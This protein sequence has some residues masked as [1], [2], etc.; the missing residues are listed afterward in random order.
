MHDIL[1][2]ATLALCALVGL[3]VGSFLNVVIY[4]LP[5]KCESIVK[6]RSFCPSCRK[7]IAWFD[8]VPLL[9][10]LILRGKCRHCGAK[11]SAR[12]FLVELFSGA[13]VTWLAY[14]FLLSRSSWEV[15]APT[16]PLFAIYS[17]LALAMVACSVIDLRLRIIPDEI[18]KPFMLL[19]PIVSF[20]YPALQS[21]TAAHFPWREQ[22]MR[23][24]M[25]ENFIALFMS[26]FG[27]FVGG[28]IIYVA[29]VLG[30]ALFRKEAMGGGDLK[31][32]AMI[33]GFVGWEMVLIAFLLACLS[34]AIIGVIIIAVTKNHYMP[35]G[36]FLAIGALLVMLF[37]DEILGI[38]KW[39]LRMLA[40]A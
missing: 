6:G 35:F 29:A 5:R 1:W 14:K 33:G 28:A 34:G 7:P 25:G 23:W 22:V 32:L 9:S 31:F 11:I 27:L 30:K 3:A 19:G 26:V 37:R 24:P 36:P 2:W 4:R 17:V 21:A 13:L 18:D 12:Y 40:G 38:V 10:Y 8:N 20:I 16:W 15:F 39:Y